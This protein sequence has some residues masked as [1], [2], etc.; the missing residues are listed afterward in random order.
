MLLKADIENKYTKSK[1]IKKSNLS[2]SYITHEQV[3]VTKDTKE[4][5]APWIAEVNPSLTAGKFRTDE[6][7]E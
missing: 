4:N 5:L 6:T 7:L 2:A 3:R 1:Q